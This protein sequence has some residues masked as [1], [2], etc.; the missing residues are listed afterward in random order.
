VA[1]TT[2]IPLTFHL[3]VLMGLYELAAGVAGFTGRISWLAILD[4]FERSPALT[5]ITGFMVF[6][7]GGVVILVHCIWTDPLA[8][9]VSAIGWIAAVEG[10]LLMVAPGPLFAFS[11]RLAG[12]QRLISLLAIAFGLLLILLGLTGRA[13]PT[14][15]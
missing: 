14:A 7:L 5:F 11:R 2:A 3:L 9:L 15:L 1:V 10:L 8:I 13:D 6:A 12:N 4:E